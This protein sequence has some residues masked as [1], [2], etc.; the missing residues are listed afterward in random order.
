MQ[1]LISESVLDAAYAWLCRRRR[2][3]PADADIWSFRRHWPEE[4]RR[5]REELLVG[6]Y[7]FSLLDRI[8]RQDGEECDLWAAR[9]ALV[10]KALAMVLATALP[11]SRLCTHLKGHGGAKGAVRAVFRNLPAYRFVLKTDVRQYYA[12][13]NHH[14]LLARLAPWIPDR[15]VMN[16]I[17]QYLKRRAERGGLVWEYPRGI[18]LGCP[19]SPILGAFYLYEV[20][21]QM[22]PRGWWYVRY[23]DDILVLAPTRWTLRQA[24]REVNQ[25]LGA[26]GLEKAPDKTFIGRIEKGFDFLGY[27]FS[28][29]GITVATATVQRFVARA[30]RLYEQE[31]ETPGGVTQLGLYVQRWVRWV[32]GGLGADKKN[33]CLQMGL[34]FGCLVRL[35]RMTLGSG[36]TRIAIGDS[37]AS[38]RKLTLA[39]PR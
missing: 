12:S 33:P 8:T 34:V 9:D 32:E 31:R 16:L 29:E 25:A 36:I 13:I 14:Q 19:L 6:H 30:T 35:T 20:D 1:R 38:L 22:A 4:K 17:G 39:T 23:M 28:P 2:D 15:R 5:I 24:V 37:M 18:A 26:L 21:V 3:Y 7:T 27:H 11:R 10:L